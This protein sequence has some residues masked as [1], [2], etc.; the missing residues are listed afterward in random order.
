MM[1]WRNK[2]NDILSNDT[3]PRSFN[4]ERPYCFVAIATDHMTSYYRY[5]STWRHAR[6][7]EVTSPSE[8]TFSQPYTPC[9][10]ETKDVITSKVLCVPS[11]PDRFL[12]KM[13]LHSAQ[14]TRSTSHQYENFQPTLADQLYVHYV[15]KQSTCQEAD[16]WSQWLRRYQLYQWHLIAKREASFRIT[17]VQTLPLWGLNTPPGGK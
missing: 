12:C 10:I 14:T 4:P 8:V 11:L 7:F 2:I 6:P 15:Y 17:R 13:E 16:L 5:I 9:S 3:P 1:D